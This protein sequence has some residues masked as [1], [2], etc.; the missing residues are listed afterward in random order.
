MTERDAAY[1]ELDDMGWFPGRRLEFYLRQ[2][3][4]PLTF[5]SSWYRITFTGIKR[6]GPEVRHSPSFGVDIKKVCSY[7]FI[8]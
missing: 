1:C 3:R 7:T 6:P 4:G 5:L 8:L 2:R